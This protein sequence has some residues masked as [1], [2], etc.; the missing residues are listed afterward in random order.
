[1]LVLALE[2]DGLGIPD[3]AAALSARGAPSGR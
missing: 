1:M 2:H 3:V